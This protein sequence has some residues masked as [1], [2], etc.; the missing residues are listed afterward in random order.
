ML[1]ATPG[2]GSI[3]P[4]RLFPGLSF[5]IE[6]ARVDYLTATDPH[7]DADSTISGASRCSG[8]VD[9]GSQGVQRHT[10]GAIFLGARDLGA[11]K[12]SAA[13]NLDADGAHFHGRS[14]RP[15]HRPTEGDSTLQLTSNV[16]SHELGV[17]LR[18]P[19]LHDVQHNVLFGQKLK[20]FAELVDL[21]ALAPDYDP[22][23]RGVNVDTDP[24]GRT[25]DV[26]FSN[27]GVVQTAIDIAL[28]HHI[29]VHQV[30]KVTIGGEPL[31]VP[32]LNDPQAKAYRVCLLSQILSPDSG[33]LQR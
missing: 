32:G 9:V 15:F 24:F 11:T 26:H 4:L 2:G 20:L 5:A 18:F 10:T 33:Y 23:S 12:S 28:D 17:Q 14:Q 25:R 6:L 7:L 29:L 27:A 19:H 16:V 13:L 31:A 22:R 21:G 30:R 1:A 8:I 3:G